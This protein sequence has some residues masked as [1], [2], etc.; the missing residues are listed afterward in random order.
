MQGIL[1]R[2]RNTR[3]E[4]VFSIGHG[5]IQPFE[6][7][8]TDCFLAPFRFLITAFEWKN[9]LSVSILISLKFRMLP[10]QIGIRSDLMLEEMSRRK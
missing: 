5:I 10:V 9:S 6:T 2:L 8:L 4:I 7:H 3:C 1:F